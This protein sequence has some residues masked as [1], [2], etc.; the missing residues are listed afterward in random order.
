MIYYTFADQNLQRRP[1]IQRHLSLDDYLQLQMLL[2][3]EQHRREQQEQYRLAQALRNL[4]V[5]KENY[6]R[7]R[8]QRIQRYMDLYLP[9]MALLE[10]QRQEEAYYR[11]CLASA[12]EQR[13]TQELWR[14]YQR[15]RQYSEDMGFEDFHAQ[16]LART[17]RLLFGQFDN[18]QE[19]EIEKEEQQEKYRT[20]AH[21][22]D[23]E[24][25]DESRVRELWDMILQQQQEHRNAENKEMEEEEYSSYDDEAVTDEEELPAQETADRDRF[26]VP[27]GD[28]LQDQ[29]IPVPTVI[30]AP[31]EPK[32]LKND[33]E[34][35][36]TLNDVRAAW[37]SEKQQQQ[38][39]QHPEPV[40]V[41]SRGQLD[42]T[43]PGMAPGTSIPSRAAFTSPSPPLQDRVLNLKDLLDQLVASRNE[44]PEARQQEVENVYAPKHVVT[45][46]EPSV[47]KPQTPSIQEAPETFSFTS[48]TPPPAAA[49]AAA[50][51]TTTDE[52]AKPGPEGAAT[53]EAFSTGAVADSAAER[54]HQI[55]EQ[56]KQN[57]PPTEPVI[58]H[59]QLHAIELELTKIE[60]EQLEPILH[61][62]L[63]FKT[64]GPEQTLQLT[65][66]TKGNR[67]FLGCEDQIMRMMLKLDAIPSNGD[68]NTRNQRRSLVKRAEAMLERLDEHKEH[69]WQ[70]ER[71]S[72]QSATT[73]TREK[74]KKRKHHKSKKNKHH[75]HH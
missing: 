25:D 26:N 17:L 28:V 73:T 5:L 14:Q 33:E 43:R 12:L 48:S 20:G 52:P 10:Q 7:E 8:A 35:D 40:H 54:V 45:A 51:G 27:S 34:S 64:S 50:E 37:P 2:R 18:E 72:A 59:P 47:D 21:Q 30:G 68:L 63:Q 24:A 66:A 60:K 13:Q 42:D 61:T 19:D 29:E 69:E 49:A 70:K 36:R 1:E 57:L 15:S 31:V 16:Q 6:R 71:T 4:K 39:Q 41:P 62:P 9:Q 74:R 46:A 56:Q 23:D 53:A 67:E 55:A 3:H 22:Y 58:Q 65:A 75:Q 38:Q 44:V 11:L 32:M